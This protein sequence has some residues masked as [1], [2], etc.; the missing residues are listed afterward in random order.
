ME[1]GLLTKAYL[2]KVSTLALCDENQSSEQS[3]AHSRGSVRY[4]GMTGQ[5]K[6]KNNEMGQK[7]ICTYLKRYWS[8]K[9]RLGQEESNFQRL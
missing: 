6:Q 9:G 7:L 8:R 1:A 2:T 3:L 4:F 5:R